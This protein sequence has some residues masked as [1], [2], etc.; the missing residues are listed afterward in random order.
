MFVRMQQTLIE[1]FKF[2]KGLKAL[3]YDELEK[4]KEMFCPLCSYVYQLANHKF[5]KEL[6]TKSWIQ[7]YSK[8][9]DSN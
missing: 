7:P 2:N 6:I 5:P 9:I 3:D 8:F 4:T 1:F